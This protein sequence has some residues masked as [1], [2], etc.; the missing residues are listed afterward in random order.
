VDLHQPMSDSAVC[1]AWGP[2]VDT[3]EWEAANRPVGE[4][5]QTDPTLC[6]IRGPRANQDAESCRIA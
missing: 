6:P 2:P 3:H 4:E 1:R 5:P